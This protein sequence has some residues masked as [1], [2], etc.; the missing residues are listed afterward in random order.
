MTKPNRNFDARG[1]GRPARRGGLVSILPLA[2]I[3]ALFAVAATAPIAAAQDPGSD[4]Y[5]PEPTQPGNTTPG[6][7]GI[8]PI[9]AAGT[10]NGNSSGDS[11]STGATGE[12]AVPPT[13]DPAVTPEEGSA[14]G[15]GKGNADERTL[16]GLAANAEQQR[17]ER[18]G[19]QTGAQLSGDGGSSGISI[20]LWIALAAI[21]VWA[22][23]AGVSNHR[24]RNGKGESKSSRRSGEQSTA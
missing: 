5:A 14:G 3:A 9:P 13:A 11:G 16:E 12:T 20:F 22:L 2:L 7:G 24:R 23:V 8:D 21:I 17:N 6:N 10:D 18:G 19:T 4:Q 1:N 15:N